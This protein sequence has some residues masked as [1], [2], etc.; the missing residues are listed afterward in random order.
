MHIGECDRRAKEQ[1]FQASITSKSI[2]TAKL[3]IVSNLIDA[4]CELIVLAKSTVVRSNSVRSYSR[5]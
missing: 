5:H 3:A 4:G 2:E 1:V